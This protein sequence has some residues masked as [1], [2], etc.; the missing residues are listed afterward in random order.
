MALCGSMGWPSS[1]RGQSSVQK[2]HWSQALRPMR[3]I[4]CQSCR[5]RRTTTWSSGRTT[6][7]A[8]CLLDKDLVIVLQTPHHHAAH[9]VACVAD[10][11]PSRRRHALGEG[12]ANRHAQG[13][14]LGHRAGDRQELL[15]DR[16]PVGPGNVERGLDV[17]HHRADVQ[18][19]ST[20][21]DEP[22]QHVVDQ[23]ELV[24]GRVGVSQQSDL[25]APRKTGPQGVD[26]VVVLV[27]DA[28]P[29]RR[30]SHQPHG[31]LKTG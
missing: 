18:G 22:S 21:G 2:L 12:D 5:L 9:H 17:D 29:A 15:D 3:A 13:H 19:D 6:H 20:G 14:R 7:T 27:L 28:D 8:G 1:H 30:R 4:W 16:L 11:G 26:D 10:R 23:D 25:H 31:R 24:T